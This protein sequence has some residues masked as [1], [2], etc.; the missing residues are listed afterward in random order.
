MKEYTTK[1]LY[2]Q[3]A[4]LASVTGYIKCLLYYPEANSTTAVS[5]YIIRVSLTANS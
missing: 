4:Y 5:S 1:C 3:L 2:Y